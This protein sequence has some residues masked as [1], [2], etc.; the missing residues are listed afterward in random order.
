M[1]MQ[2]KATPIEGFNESLFF[3]FIEKMSAFDGK[4]IIVTLL[5]G[6]KF[7]AGI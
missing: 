2:S 4:N 5:D 7:E 1:D 6:T 3:I